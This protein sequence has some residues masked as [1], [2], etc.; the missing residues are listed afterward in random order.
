MKSPAELD[1]DLS[2][3]VKV[4]SSECQAVVEQHTAIRHIQSGHRDLVLIPLAKTLSQGNVKGSVLRQI[5][6]RI[7]RR[8]AIRS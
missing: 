5:V 8:L 2:W 3:I 7:L 1:V 6:A 4:E